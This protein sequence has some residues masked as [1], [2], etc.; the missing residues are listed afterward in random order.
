MTSSRRYF[1]LDEGCA[2]SEIPKMMCRV[3]ADKQLPLFRF[4]PVE[5]PA[6]AGDAA[7]RPRLPHNTNDIIP[8]ILPDPSLTTNRKDFVASL[9]NSTLRLSLGSLLGFDLELE[10]E[11]RVQLETAAV[12][13]YSLNNPSV[14]FQ[15]LMKNEDYAKD[16]RALLEE[17]KWGKAWLVV[18]FL[19]TAGATWNK[20][21]TKRS[22]AGVSLTAPLTEAFGMPSLPGLEVDPGVVLEKGIA[23]ESGSATVTP[24]EEIFAVAYA[25]V[26]IKYYINTKSGL[27]LGR[28]EKVGP[29]KKAKANHLAFGSDSDSGDEASDVYSDEGSEDGV[30]RPPRSETEDFSLSFDF[31]G[32]NDAFELVE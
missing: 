1:V 19:V 10:S 5:L 32:M 20:T 7:E 25:E 23:S 22:K 8:L 29:P 27:G 6:V 2:S 17:S 4:A 3:V 14:V 12:K 28:T 24:D 21:G 26:K 15:S 13:R 16:V 9:P 30:E 31:V 11:Q 18:G